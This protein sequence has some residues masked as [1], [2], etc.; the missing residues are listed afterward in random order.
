M[1]K[2]LSH[3]LVVVTITLLF[4]LFWWSLYRTVQSFDQSSNHL[5]ELR[6]Q[7]DQATQEVQQLE[8]D[9]QAAKSDLTKEKIVR[10]ELLQQ[11]PGE[12]VVKIEWPQERKTTTAAPDTLTPWEEWQKLLAP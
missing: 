7:V 8:Q 5:A 9:L 3:P 10:N 11:K 6:G 1:N 12:Y 4:V 2:L